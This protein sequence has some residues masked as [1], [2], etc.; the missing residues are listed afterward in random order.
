MDGRDCETELLLKNVETARESIQ[1]YYRV[2]E[3]VRD[4]SV[5]YEGQEY[6]LQDICIR[7]SE[8]SPCQV[9]LGSVQLDVRKILLVD[10]HFGSVGI[11]CNHY[12]CS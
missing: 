12:Q 1:A 6:A 2:Y 9:S 11:Q 10:Q 8:D 5:I 4:F 3:A 7:P